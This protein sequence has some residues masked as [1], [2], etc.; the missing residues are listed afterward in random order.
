M[1]SSPSTFDFR[2]KAQSIGFFETPVA[3]CQLSEG[4]YFLD[5]I[6]KLV[7]QRRENDPG[8]T[9][10]NTGSWHSD[11]NMLQWGGQPARLLGEKVTSIARRMSHFKGSSPDAFDWPLQM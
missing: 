6:E 1:T 10:S 2:V 7:R 3:L 8:V 9:R 5:E 11:T 4:E